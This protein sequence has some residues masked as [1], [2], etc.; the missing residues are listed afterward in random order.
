VSVHALVMPVPLHNT[1]QAARGNS[2]GIPAKAPL[3]PVG[4]LQASSLVDRPLLLHP[5]SA[6]SPLLS[7]VASHCCIEGREARRLII[8]FLSCRL[9]ARCCRASDGLSGG[10]EPQL[11]LSFALHRL[12]STAAFGT[13]CCS[14]TTL[15]ALHTDNKLLHIRDGGCWHGTD[16]PW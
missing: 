9:P 8:K 16:V 7:P 2:L 6:G 4:Q 14:R 1:S 5:C 13:T 12:N 3:P 10:V 11:V 15:K